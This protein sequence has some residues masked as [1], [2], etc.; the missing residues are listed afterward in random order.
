MIKFDKKSEIGSSSN[1]WSRRDLARLMAGASL[2]SLLPAGRG[3]A[4]QNAN[5]LNLAMIGEPQT[6]DPMAS[7]ADLVSGIMMHVYES[8]YTWDAD[9]NPKPMLATEMPKVSADGLLY[10]IE[11]RKG[12][13]LHSGR[14]LDIEDVIASLKRW[15]EMTPRGKA[16]GA[17]V[18]TIE[19]KGSHGLTISLKAPV[20][21]LL[22]H[23]A[24]PSG[25]AAIMAKEAI[26]TPLVSFVGTGPYKFQERKPDQYVIL[27]RFDGYSARNEAPSGYAGKREAKITELRFIPVPNANTRV[28][29]VVAGQYHFAEQLPVESYKR[30]AATA[31]IKPLLVMPYGFPYLVLNTKQGKFAEK[32]VR[33]AFQLALNSTE[34]LMAAFGDD[35]FFRATAAH[36]PK[37]SPFHSNAG[38]AVYD[39]ADTAAAKKLLAEGKYDGTPVRILNSKQF[40]FHNRIALVM[41]EQL[42]A[43]GFKVQ[44]DVVDWATL[45]QRRSDPALYDVFITHSSFL[46]EPMLSPPQLGTGAPGWWDSPAKT[47]TL[48]AFNAESDP[49]KRG[50]LWGKVQEVVYDEVPYIRVGD[51]AALSATT[52]KL[53]GLVPMPSPAFWNVELS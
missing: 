37:A 28:E 17:S 16:V 8:L 24:L 25:Y 23:M 3:P 38:A 51:F 19:A 11:I 36:F 45:I 48:A 21:A 14:D 43:A 9:L 42:Q 33:Q 6:L 30:I 41:S 4:A 7:T 5:S 53:K 1:G 18:A 29:G 22:T 32:K 52:A 34:M 35:K 20:P 26:A 44:L 15:M 40:E 10:E 2:L 12:V 47:A 50:A 27:T 13:K 39:K 46:P 49:V 31:S